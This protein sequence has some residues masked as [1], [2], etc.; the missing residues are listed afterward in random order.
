MLSGLHV[1]V[2]YFV[3][4]C[5]VAPSLKVD[6]FMVY[7]QS[8]WV[9]YPDFF[10][11]TIRHSRALS[12]F[13]LCNSYLS[14]KQYLFSDPCAL[15]NDSYLLCLWMFNL[16]ISAVC[17]GEGIMPI[18]CIILSSSDDKIKAVRQDTQRTGRCLLKT[19][20]TVS[21]NEIYIQWTRYFLI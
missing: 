8:S 9:L 11:C 7:Y 16:G 17:G 10:S 2:L 3:D 15:A 20:I 12:Q 4:F 6:E 1:L 13:Y 21:T 14:E 18:L 19:I 5:F